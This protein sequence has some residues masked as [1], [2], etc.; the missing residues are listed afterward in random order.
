MAKNL[1]RDTKL[2]AQLGRLAHEV[3]QI[4]DVNVTLKLWDGSRIPLGANVSGDLVISIVD[5]GVILPW[6]CGVGERSERQFLTHDLMLAE[7]DVV[8]V[9]FG[10]QVE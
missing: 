6:I 3:G 10:D 7:D 9:I 5:P 4:L 8:D 2:A 1:K